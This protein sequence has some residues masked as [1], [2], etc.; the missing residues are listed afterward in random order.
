MRSCPRSPTAT[1]VVFVG[2][3][4]IS[5]RDDAQKQAGEFY[6]VR[7]VRWRG[8]WAACFPTPLVYTPLTSAARDPITLWQAGPWRRGARRHR[9]LMMML[10]R[11]RAVL[12]ATSLVF[13]ESF[14]HFDPEAGLSWACACESAWMC[15]CAKRAHS[16]GAFARVALEVPSALQM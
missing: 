13:D 4:T 11:R 2:N 5:S 14:S 8:G 1:P 7:V 12:G 3:G 15:T 9:V 16:N 6:E 10:R